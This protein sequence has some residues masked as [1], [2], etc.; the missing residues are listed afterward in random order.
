[1][2]PT[3]NVDELAGVP[4][5]FEKDRSIT[6]LRCSIFDSTTENIMEHMDAAVAFIE[7][8][9]YHGK[10]LVHCYRGV[11]RSASVVIGYLMKEKGMRFKDAL[12]YTLDRRDVVQ[13]NSAFTKQMEAWDVELEKEREANKGTD[14][15]KKYAL[16]ESES[17][18]QTMG[19]VKG[20]HMPPHLQGHSRSSRDEEEGAGV[21]KGPQLPPHLQHLM[22]RGGD[23]EEEETGTRV[24][25][26]DEEASTGVQ[27]GPQLPP[28]LQHLMN[29]GG[30]AEEEE[31]GTRVQKGPQLPPHLQHLMNPADGDEKSP[32]SGEKRSVPF[33]VEGHDVK[34][35]KLETTNEL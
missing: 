18:R 33:G 31:T 10:V 12:Q 6:Y 25:N 19:K 5:F 4:N 3:K 20:P 29:R 22:N 2:G 8:A 30:D 24:Q 23:A 35:S 26:D 17:P 14:R 16:D 28:H 1:M 27:K 11:S 13:P 7:N 32:C 21:Q 9:K 34:R 15:E